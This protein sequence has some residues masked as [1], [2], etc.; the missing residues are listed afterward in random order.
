MAP[1]GL[2]VLFTQTLDESESRLLSSE[3]KPTPR[4]MS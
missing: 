2:P 4:A 3:N 1:N